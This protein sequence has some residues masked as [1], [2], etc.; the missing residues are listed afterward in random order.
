MSCCPPGSHGFLASNPTAAAGE[1]I[2]LSSGLD[3][4]VVGN[5]GAGNGILLIPDVW[6]WDSGRI[7]EV[8][9]NLAE[10][11]NAYAVIPRVLSQAPENTGL[12]GGTNGDGLPPDFDLMKRGK[13][14]GPFMGNFGWAS[15][16]KYPIQPKYASAIAHMKEKGCVRIA[17]IGFCFGCGILEQASAA[18][19]DLICCAFPH[20][21][22]HAMLGTKKAVAMASDISCPVLL[23]PAGNDPDIYD[24]QKGSFYQNLKAKQPASMS[25]P[26]PDME[27]GWTIR[28]DL[29]DAK[30]NRDVTRFMDETQKFF[31]QYLVAGKM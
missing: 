29:K 16:A 25:S 7:R 6:G 4:Y 15:P 14:L 10:K 30:I 3:C 27:H 19:G 8:A 23:M 31:S 11:L 5:A 18:G 9:G 1:Q 21:S 26:F 17:G 28:G 13:D 2:K 22:C 12:E 20:P 24:P